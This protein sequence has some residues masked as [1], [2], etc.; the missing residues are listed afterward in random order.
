MRTKRLLPTVA[1]AAALL[2]TGCSSG[3]EASTVPSGAPGV[4][5]SQSAS[6]GPF[7]QADVTFAQQ[8]IPHHAQALAMASLAAGRTNTPAT[9]EL[10][11][12]I[13]GEQ[14]PEID[15]L[16]GYLTS[17]GAPVA[18]TGGAMP[19]M[20]HGQGHG[21]PSGPTMPGMMTEQEM[22]AL[23]SLTGA[24]FDRRWLQMMTSHHQGAIV[25][26]QTELSQGV[27]P[28]AKQLATS[29]IAAQQAEIE[30]MA[31]LLKQS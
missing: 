28:Q 18:P 9:L 10:A 21:S 16:T 11:N 23:R 26:A 12:R 31:L 14:Q 17:W 7:N 13:R 20:D 1:V 2:L 24:A 19:G 22:T 29:I 30:Q 4:A 3:N 5:S 25:M 27:N 15:Q 8:M 6:N